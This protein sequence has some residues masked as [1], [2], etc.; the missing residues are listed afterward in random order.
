MAYARISSTVWMSRSSGALTTITTVPIRQRAQPILPSCPRRSLRTME[1]STAPIS[2][3]SAPSGVTRM[4]GA[5]VYAIK[6][7]T[8]PTTMVA[9]PAHQIGF[10]R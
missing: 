2:T 8:S 4:G 5:K 9:M 3:L 6:L 1:A 7:A 10:W